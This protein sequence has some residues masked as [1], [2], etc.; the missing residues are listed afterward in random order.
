V[1]ADAS[2]TSSLPPFPDVREGLDTS[3]SKQEVVRKNHGEAMWEKLKIRERDRLLGFLFVSSLLAFIAFCLLALGLPHAAMG[4]G[5][6]FLGTVCV[7]VAR[8]VRI[9]LQCRSAPMPT[10]PL[11]S[12]EKLKAR[13]KLLKPRAPA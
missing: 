10:G 12:D 7:L 2:P 3:L 9:W 1:L 8:F 4:A 6:C 11:S 5:V 13:A